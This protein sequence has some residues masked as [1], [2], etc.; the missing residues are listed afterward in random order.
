MNILFDT[1]LL[2]WMARE[3][4]RLPDTARQMIA[5]LD[6]ALHF[7][8]ASIW[9]IAIKHGRNRADF[10]FDPRK[11]RL[12]LLDQDFREIAITGD[13]AVIVADLPPIH[14]DPFDRLLLAQAMT[15]GLTLLTTDAQLA[16][17]PGPIQ[18]V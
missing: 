3:P 13:H 15:E 14:K 17:Y 7:S 12:N 8:A 16:R 1:Q 11:L 2:I 5:D 18:H 10:Q 4:A 9:E 6:N